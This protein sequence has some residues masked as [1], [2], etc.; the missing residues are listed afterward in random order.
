VEIYY[1]GL[2]HN[3][4][5][6]T[7]YK[8]ATEKIGIQTV[9]RPINKL[10]LTT[11][12]STALLSSALFAELDSRHVVTMETSD[13]VTIDKTPR[14]KTH[15]EIEYNV[16][17]VLEDT[18]FIPDFTGSHIT[19]VVF[20]KTKVSEA[21]RSGI[22]GSSAEYA[23][24]DDPREFVLDKLAKLESV[25]FRT[26]Q[27]TGPLTELGYN[28]D[29]SSAEQAKSIA[30]NFFDSVLLTIPGG[31]VTVL[32]YEE[33][34]TTALP[35]YL[36]TKPIFPSSITKAMDGDGVFPAPSS[37]LTTKF[38]NES[39]DCENDDGNK[40]IVRLRGEEMNPVSRS[41]VF[42]Q[43]KYTEYDLDIKVMDDCASKRSLKAGTWCSLIDFFPVQIS[44]RIC[45]Q[46]GF[47]EGQVKDIHCK[48]FFQ[49]ATVV[50]IETDSSDSSN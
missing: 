29:C 37:S 23:K 33:A 14:G 30:Y 28:I 49:S 1:N 19:L 41:F 8:G 5:Y 25:A 32:A 31:N 27:R 22:L 50:N 26:G 46:S 36:A 38:S 18:L 17:R 39:K 44:F 6:L 15:K 45:P 47:N 10:A 13:H 48:H 40:L 4:T 2:L 24:K 9:N 16:C 21:V 34:F 42:V 11:A 35:D 3:G 20:D 7:D 43:N 12:A